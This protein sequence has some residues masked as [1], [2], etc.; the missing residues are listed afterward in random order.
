MTT[1]QTPCKPPS[2]WATLPPSNPPVSPLQTPSQP[3][4]H[5]PRGCTHALRG[6]ARPDVTFIGGAYLVPM[7]HLQSRG[8]VAGGGYA[9]AL[10]F[11]VSILKA[12]HSLSVISAS[13]FNRAVK[14]SNFPSF[15]SSKG[16]AERNRKGWKKPQ[17]GTSA[18]KNFCACVHPVREV[19]WQRYSSISIRCLACVLTKLTTLFRSLLSSWISL[20]SCSISVTL[21]SLC[22]F[23]WKLT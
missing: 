12:L 14:A 10:C 20:C 16:C 17:K 15:Q 5:T 3:H 9:F 22:Q 11:K 13:R 21:S 6:D 8:G 4:P 7:P 19:V 23:V 2:N 18:A 1:M